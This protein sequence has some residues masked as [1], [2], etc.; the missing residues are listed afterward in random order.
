MLLSITAGALI[1][2]CGGG[3]EQVS[4]AELVQKGDQICGEERST[5]DRIQA[6]PPP[7]ASVAADQTDEL[8]KSTE[9]ANSKL[10]DLEPPD[11]LRARYDQYLDARDGAVDEMQHGKDAAD[12]QNS[13]AYGAAQAAVARSAPQRKKLAASLG[14]KVCSSSSAA[15]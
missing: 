2:G 11:E 8:I 4:A 3:K 14:F 13:D 1:V 12:D 10:R 9:D 5:F 15:A 6:Q 7:N